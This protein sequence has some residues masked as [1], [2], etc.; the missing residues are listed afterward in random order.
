[1][2]AAQRAVL[3]ALQR[4]SSDVWETYREQLAANPDAIEL[5]QTFI[6]SSW[7]RVAVHSDDTPIAG[8]SARLLMAGGKLRWRDALSSDARRA[9]VRVATPAATRGIYDRGTMRV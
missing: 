4:R 5:P 9:D 6:D 3:E 8:P 2:T 7:V 1:M